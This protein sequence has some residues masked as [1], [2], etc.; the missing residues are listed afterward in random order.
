MIS[1]ATKLP[2]QQPPI[3]PSVNPPNQFVNQGNMDKRGRQKAKPIPEETGQPLLVAQAAGNR[4]KT[5]N[6]EGGG[7]RGEGFQRVKV[8]S[9]LIT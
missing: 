2:K 3:T 7:G 5:L 6:R 9:W 4:S 1:S 8:E